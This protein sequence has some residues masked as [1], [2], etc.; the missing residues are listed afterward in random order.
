[1]LPQE[2]RERK[3]L[4]TRVASCCHGIFLRERSVIPNQSGLVLPR[5]CERGGNMIA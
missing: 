3:V 1:V 5:G 4:D 2:M